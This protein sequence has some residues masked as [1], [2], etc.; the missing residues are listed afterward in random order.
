MKI[1]CYTLLLLALFWVLN[2]K[3]LVLCEEP[4]EIPFEE[5][6]DGT[7]EDGFCYFDDRDDGVRYYEGLHAHGDYPKL[8]FIIRTKKMD[9]YP[10]EPI[11]IKFY[12]RNDSD[13]E[14]HIWGLTSAKNYTHLWKLFHSNYDEVVKTQKWEEEF[15]KHKRQGKSGPPSWA[16]D[17]GPPL[18]IKLQ[19]RQ[20]RE[21]DWVPLNGYYDL[22]KP[23]TYELT[24]F[25]TSF[26]EGQYYE[27]PLQSNTLTFRVLEGPNHVPTV[28]ERKMENTLIYTNPPPGEEVFKQP[29]PPKNVFYVTTGGEPPV[30]YLDE[31]PTLYYRRLAKE[32]EAAKAAKSPDEAKPPTE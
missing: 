7:D 10:G 13:S 8:K 17:G 14:I 24:C 1:Y 21:L 28:E 5:L 11:W 16:A 3:H 22:T 4:Q 26:I 6:F 23:D 18:F 27:T 12:V 2:G 29:K 32:D 19:P 9:F 30:V 15:Q 25:H 31:S 20:E